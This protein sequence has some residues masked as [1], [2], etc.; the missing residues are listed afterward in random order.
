VSY[1]RWSMS[2]CIPNVLS[3]RWNMSECIPNV[4]SIR[5]SMSECIPNVLSIR[6]SQDECVTN[7]FARYI[8]NRRLYD[9]YENKLRR[10]SVCTPKNMRVSKRIQTTVSTVRLTSPTQKK[11]ALSKAQN[12]TQ[13]TVKNHTTHTKLHHA[14]PLT[15][16]P[17]THTTP[18]HSSP[19]T[20]RPATR[21]RSRRGPPTP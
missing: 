7:V 15:P 12:I 8:G 18:R 4:L 21:G 10:R 5:W 11:K 16:P 19:L 20:P 6:G 13:H 1:I 14:P 9:L 2:E 17:A 3:I